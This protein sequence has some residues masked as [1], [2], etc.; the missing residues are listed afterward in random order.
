MCNNPATFSC[1]SCHCRPLYCSK[2][3]QRADWKLHKLLCSSRPSFETPPTAS[4]RRAIV[5]LTNGEINFTW[6][7]TEMVADDE[8]DDG[9]SWE[10]P[11][12]LEKYFDGKRPNIQTFYGN[13]VRGRKLKDHI[14]LRYND[15]AMLDGSE[16]NLAVCKVVPGMDDGG[17]VWRAPLVALKQT[18]SW[19]NSEQRSRVN[20]T[21]GY[22]HLDMGD[23]R[24][25]V[26]YLTGWKRATVSYNNL[27]QP[28]ETYSRNSF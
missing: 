9:G 16:K 18:N 4:S 13:S 28:R 8:S 21:P 25:V 26:D 24:E 17:A 5:F 27:T 12:G 6:E 3:C 10:S 1:S 14:D 15:D 22:G 2:S 19:L 23:F 20:E 11:V 7:T